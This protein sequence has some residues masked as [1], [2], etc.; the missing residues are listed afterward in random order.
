MAGRR[1]RQGLTCDPFLSR[2]SHS[3]G[4]PDQ[5]RRDTLDGAQAKVWYKT[6][7]T[8]TKNI[9]VLVSGGLDSITLNAF[10]QSQGWVTWPIT[11]DYGQTHRKEIEAAQAL[12]PGTY[13]FDLKGLGRLGGS[14]LTEDTLPIP[15]GHY[16]APSMKVTVVPNRN[17]VF[18]SLAAAYAISIGHDVVAYAAHSGDHVIYPDCRPDFIQAMR[19]AFAKCDFHPVHLSTPFAERDKTY[20]AKLAF[21]LGVDIARTWSCYKGGEAHCG[22]CGTCVERVEAFELAGIEDP[23]V[24]A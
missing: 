17:M 14:A 16:E 7:V 11:F 8:H 12:A 24:Y 20:I 10:L 3:A 21:A 5:L 23:T 4:L 15:D 19:P 1:Y 22:T 18:L 6:V 2:R 9:V 13:V